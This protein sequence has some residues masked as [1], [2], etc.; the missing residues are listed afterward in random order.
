LQ[1]TAQQINFS[2]AL[3]QEFITGVD[4]SCASAEQVIHGYDVVAHQQILLSTTNPVVPLSGGVLND[5]RKLYFGTYDGTAQT[6]TLHRI[7]LSTGTGTPGTLTED[8]SA[9]VAVVPSFVA[10]VPK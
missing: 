8:L 3:E 6:A 7:D 2:P 5:G 4:P 1:C 9:S 10:V